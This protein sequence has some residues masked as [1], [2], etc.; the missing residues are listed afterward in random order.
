MGADIGC[1]VRPAVKAF[2][3]LVRAYDVPPCRFHDL[4][5]VCATVLLR[6]GVPMPVVSRVLG[7]S[8]INI[9]VDTYGRVTT[10][11]QVHEAMD[12]AFGRFAR[13]AR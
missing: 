6:A 5:H 1:Q 13:P 7:H 10:D 8:N 11:W 3:R 12:A 2:S 4:R 9:T